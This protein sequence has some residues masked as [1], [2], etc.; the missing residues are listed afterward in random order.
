MA[1]FDSLTKEMKLQAIETRIMSLTTQLYGLL[2]AVGLDPED[3]DLSTFNPESG[4][5][6][7]YLGYAPE[8]A[9]LKGQISHAEEMRKRVSA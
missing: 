7:R 5:N 3:V 9:L 2:I 4:L 1:L 8:I 6:E